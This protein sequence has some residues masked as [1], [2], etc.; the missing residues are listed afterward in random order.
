MRPAML[1]LCFCLMHIFL[2]IRTKGH[3][4][5]KLS[6]LPRWRNRKPAYVLFEQNRNS[7][8]FYIFKIIYDFIIKVIH[9]LAKKTQKLL[10]WKDGV[11]AWLIN[12]KDNVGNRSTVILYKLVVESVANLLHL[13]KST[14]SQ[15]ERHWMCL[16]PQ[17]SQQEDSC[18][19]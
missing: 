5:L 1:L 13:D 11:Y 8:S 10:T 9:V 7:F 18:S 12:M 4:S 2:P 19:R 16:Y 17:V 6:T 3:K 15:F 14:C